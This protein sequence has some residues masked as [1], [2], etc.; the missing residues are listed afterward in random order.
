MSATV[1]EKMTPRDRVLCT[2]RRQR[3][4]RMP[5]TLDVGAS[6]G[7]A[8]SYLGLYRRQAGPVE[9]ADYFD[10][11]VRVIDAPP[12]PAALDF[13]AWYDAVPPGTTFDE[14]GVGHVVSEAFPLGMELHPW[15]S[16]ASVHQIEDYPFPFFE[17]E[18][19][20]VQEI[21]RL[22]DRGYAVSAA[23]GSINEW[24]YALRGMEGFMLD[25]MDEHDMARAAL[26]RVTALCSAMG[27]ALG[28]AGVDVLCF[29]GDMGSQTSL[30]L[31]LS[32]WEEWIQ[33]RWR[34]VARAVREVSPSAVLFYHSCGSVEPIIPGIVKA[35]FD[36]LNPV[37]P[38][39]MDPVRIARQ[40][41]SQISLWGGIGMQK[42][43]LNCSPAGVRSAVREL[44]AQWSTGGIVTV[45]Q[46]I[47]PDVPWE[48]VTALV[49]A[50]REQ[51]TR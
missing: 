12:S 31:G 45:A 11:D 7:I 1:G 40:Y 13:S 46:T 41:G 43:M 2:L 30:L 37:Q 44:A 33:P 6:A 25:I 47:L 28:R 16:F 29:Y 18:E 51:S 27:T 48:N 8:A 26:D 38:E 50:V 24:C 32:T 3:A 10:Y 42:T 22:H 21:R 39:C 34:Q 23:C 9:P 19:N 15:E 49:D 4:D 17:L 36:V 14:F 35:G 20:A 5:L